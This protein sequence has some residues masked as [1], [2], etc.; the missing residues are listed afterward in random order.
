MVDILSIN[1]LDILTNDFN[2][3]ELTGLI[4]TWI[5]NYL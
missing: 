2:H 5:K 3:M 4:Y 1:I